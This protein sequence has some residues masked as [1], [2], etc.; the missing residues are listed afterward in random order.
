[1]RVPK[2]FDIPIAPDL[3]EDPTTLS[4]DEAVE[5]IFVERG[6]PVL[7]GASGKG[8]SYYSVAQ[9][10]ACLFRETYDGPHADAQRSR[11]VD[12]QVPAPLQIGALF[13]VLEAL[14]Y[15]A[16][17]EG[18]ALV[19]PDRGGIC[20]LEFR[21]PGRVKEWAPPV[22]AAD[23]LLLA[24]KTMCGVGEEVLEGRLQASIEGEACPRGDGPNRE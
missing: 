15:A 13:H 19:Q 11:R 16:E 24:L 21:G 3:I 22:D 14:Y 23:Q 5:Q 4:I 18:G 9:R 12:G 7:G 1:M 10:C 17:L 20:A 6:W 2:D 8:W